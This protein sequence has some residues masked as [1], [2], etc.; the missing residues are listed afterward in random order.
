MIWA[1]GFWLLLVVALAQAAALAPTTSIADALSVNVAIS[2]VAGRPFEYGWIRGSG[3]AA[4]VVGTIVVGRL[5]GPADL[6]P[7][8]WMNA[9]LLIVA[10]CAT[11]FVPLLFLGPLYITI[12]GLLWVRC[13]PFWRFRDFGS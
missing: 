13:T 2:Q 12:V 4:F 7:V 9:S 11:V 6:I 5:I 10:A 3:S 8:V 1:D